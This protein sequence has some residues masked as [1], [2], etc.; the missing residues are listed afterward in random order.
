[1]PASRRMMAT[2]WPMCRNDGVAVNMWS[3]GYRDLALRLN[4]WDLG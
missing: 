1:V 2:V 3:R 4:Y